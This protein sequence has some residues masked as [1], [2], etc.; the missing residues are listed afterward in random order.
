MEELTGLTSGIRLIISR[1]A[2]N[3]RFCFS[4]HASS[5]SVPTLQPMTVHHPFPDPTCHDYKTTRL[6]WFPCKRFESLSGA[7]QAP[8]ENAWGSHGM[9][10][11]CLSGEEG[12]KLTCWTAGPR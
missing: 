7:A 11:L 10:K 8:S 5:P 1:L 2:F 6:F 9:T 3:R 12:R 4:P